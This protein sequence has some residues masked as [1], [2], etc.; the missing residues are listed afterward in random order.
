MP[1]LLS[2]LALAGDTWTP[3]RSGVDYLHRTTS[4]PQDI[5]AVRV[6]LTVPNVGLHASADS[7]GVERHVNT[8]TFAQNTNVLVAINADW[9]DGG[10]P[11]GLAM[12][13]G[14][15]WHSH[16]PDDTVGGQWGYFAC[17]ATK[18]CTITAERPLDYAWWFSQPYLPPYRYFQ[19]V[20]A[21]GNLMVVDGV[22]QAGCY[23][24]IKNP[25]SAICLE[26][27]GTTLWLLAI[28]GR[29]GQA[30][31]MTCDEVRSLMLELGCWNGAMLDGGGST[32][33]VIEGDV[34]NNPSDGS[35]RTVSNHLGIV[36]SD[37][38]DSRCG[39]SNGRWCDGTVISACQGGRFI[40]TGDC[41]YYGAGCEEDGDWAYCVDYR[42]PQAQ[43]NNAVCLDGSRFAACS[44][45]QYSEGDCGVFGLAC[46]SDAG[47]VGCMD[48]RC[49]AGPHSAFCTDAGLYATCTDGSYAEGDCA[50]YGRVCWEGSGT[51]SCVEAACSSGPD[52]QTCTDAG[53]YEV[54][55]GGSYT[56]TDCSAAGQ[57]CEPGVGCVE[58]GT[59]GDSEEEE[60]EKT[61]GQTPGTP[62]SLGGL[63]CSSP[64][65]EGGTG[66]LLGVLALRRRN[67]ARPA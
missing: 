38:I 64:G 28:D 15:L 6:D 41:A 14:S 65:V 57:R 8:S 25:R 1:L 24:S 7:D 45:G 42:C 18:D 49:E 10:T 21:N 9:S 61:N 58:A 29:S 32:T 11:V 23:D 46:G 43:G 34:K 5:F 63:G 26:A 36:Y 35:L 27:N 12:S 44:D 33:L 37:S 51:A 50:A 67:R 22:P 47:G 13:D 60:E 31:G 62:R 40:G 55:A 17:T 4:E 19:A 16:I 3:I 59:G 30:A 54:C 53:V 2:T 52:S 20:G 39:V 56:A 66:L 48:P